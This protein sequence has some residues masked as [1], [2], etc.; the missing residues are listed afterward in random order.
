MDPN[1]TARHFEKALLTLLGETFDAARGNYLDPGMALG[2][3][4]ATVSPEE[5][6]APVLADGESIAGH[7][8]HLAFSLETLVKAARNRQTE[9]VDWAES[10][11]VKTVNEVTWPELRTRY[12]SA[13]TAFLELLGEVSSWE[14]EYEV[15]GSMGVLTHTAYHLGA[16]RTAL[17]VIR[18]RAA[19]EGADAPETK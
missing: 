9:P 4:L 8:G 3:T 11:R 6:S 1:V 14:A 13:E 18:S 5:A 12:K 16:I 19:T 2:E 15:F 10:W 7:V 17:H